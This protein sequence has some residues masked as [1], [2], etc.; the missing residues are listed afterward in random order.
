MATLGMVIF[1]MCVQ[2]H[3][4]LHYLF[5]SVNCFRLFVVYR[6]VIVI[7]RCGV[8]QY[9]FGTYHYEVIGKKTNNKFSCLMLFVVVYKLVIHVHHGISI[10]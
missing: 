6:L 4:V 5:S 9:H 7:F 8:I 1:S 3:K 2:S 10:C